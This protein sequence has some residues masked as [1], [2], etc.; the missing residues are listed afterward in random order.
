MRTV[1]APL[2][3][4]TDVVRRVLAHEVGAAVE[5]P[6]TGFFRWTEGSA[7]RRVRYTL[8]TYAAVPGTRLTLDAQSE[9]PAW[10]LATF[11][12]LLLATAGLAVLLIVPILASAR[13]ER[14]RE[15]RIFGILRAV[16][17]ALTP[18]GGSYRVAQGALVHAP[19]SRPRVAESDPVL[20][21]DE[22]EDA[23]HERRS[24]RKIKLRRG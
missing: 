2:D 21:W 20:P 22:D 8:R 12:F 7:L 11:A 10:L 4:C 9:L 15:V 3:V 24:G 6:A 16:D 5:E 19:P 14:Q 17:R 18:S 13:A 1:D 23:P